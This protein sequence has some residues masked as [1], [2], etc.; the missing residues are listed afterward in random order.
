MAESAETV[1]SIRGQRV[2]KNVQFDV[3][4]LRNRWPVCVSI[5]LE[6]QRPR[7]TQI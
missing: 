2:P 6:T 5:D 7:R 3:S 1:N 4:S